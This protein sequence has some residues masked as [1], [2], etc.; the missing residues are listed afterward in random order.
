VKNERLAALERHL[1]EKE[2][3]IPD[4]NGKPSPAPSAPQTLKPAPAPQ[5]KM[6]KLPTGNDPLEG[7]K[8][9]TTKELGMEQNIIDLPPESPKPEPKNRKNPHGDT[10]H[11]EIKD[12]DTDRDNEEQNNID[13]DTSDVDADENEEL[14]ETSPW[15]NEPDVL[16]NLDLKTLSPEEKNRL[17]NILKEL[18]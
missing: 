9:D 1:E 4:Q 14:P 11:P 6:I 13:F 3:N 10:Y 7:L 2:Q 12:P 18:I 5:N 15:E 8:L 16:K 17:K